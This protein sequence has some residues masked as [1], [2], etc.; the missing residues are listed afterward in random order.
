MRA[1]LAVVLFLLPCSTPPLFGQKQAITRTY[2]SI[3]QPHT[4]IHI[5]PHTHLSP[6]APL[7][8][9][10]PNTTAPSHHTK[11]PL[12]Q[13]ILTLTLTLPHQ[14]PHPTPPQ[15]FRLLD[16]RDGKVD[17]KIEAAPRRASSGEREREKGFVSGWLWLYVYMYVRVSLSSFSNGKVL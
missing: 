13:H 4:H 12:P 11:T 6:P 17:G 10:P 1:A 3:N 5:P 16:S 8:T 2:P 7:T 14:P 9:P 15:A